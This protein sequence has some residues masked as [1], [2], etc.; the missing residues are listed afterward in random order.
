[1]GIKRN[2]EIVIFGIA[3]TVLLLFSGVA[4]ADYLR[5]DTIPDAGEWVGHKIGVHPTTHNIYAPSIL[6]GELRVF[7]HSDYSL[8]HKYSLLNAKSLKSVDFNPAENK[9]YVVGVDNDRHSNLWVI[10]ESTHTIERI[11]LGGGHVFDVAYNPTSNKIYV[12]VWGGEAGLYI[13]DVDDD[14]SITS[15]NV[16]RRCRGVAV[17][18]VTNKVYVSY[19]DHSEVRGGARLMRIDG[20]TND[21]IGVLDLPRYS[22]PAAVAVDDTTNKVYVV[23]QGFNLVTVVDGETLNRAFINLGPGGEGYDIGPG[24]KKIWAVG[25]LP[26]CNKAFTV[27][28]ELAKLYIINTNTNELESVMDI[29]GFPF[30][31][32]VEQT[33]PCRVYVGHNVLN[34]ISVFQ[35]PW[36]CLPSPGITAGPG[37]ESN[38]VGTCHQV[39]MI[40]ANDSGSP[41]AG[42]DMYVEVYPCSGCTWFNPGDGNTVTGRVTTDAEGKA[43]FCYTGLNEGPDLIHIWADINGNGTRDPGEPTATKLYKTWYEDSDADGIPDEVEGFVDDTDDDGVLN[44]LDLDSDGDMIPDSSEGTGDSDGDGIPNY[45]DD[46][47]DGDGISDYWEGQI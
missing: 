43:L 29:E 6:S 12:T 24:A 38:R 32:G 2:E 37:N 30:G 8:I 10:D 18:P 25:V 23:L 17:N 26:L 42:V 47:S 34:K 14:Y 31:V 3:L 35:D 44:Y 46:N 16:Y 41:L 28:F 21:I 33:H 1:M 36:G 4:S 40:L 45:L 39:A 19:V 22:Y 20:N 11:G 27:N 5:I 13:V 7:N 9:V 15:L